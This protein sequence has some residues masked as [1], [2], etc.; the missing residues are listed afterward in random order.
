M[1]GMSCNKVQVP[2]TFVQCSGAA[3]RKQLSLVFLK[4]TSSRGVGGTGEIATERNRL[5]KRRLCSHHGPSRLLG[6]N[7]FAKLASKDAYLLFAT[8]TCPL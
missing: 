5:L 8:H 6:R 4:N 7:D 1:A 2:D 3:T